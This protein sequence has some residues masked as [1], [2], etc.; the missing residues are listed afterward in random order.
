M[1]K[2]REVSEKELKFEPYIS[3]NSKRIA[4]KNLT[5]EEAILEKPII[6]ARN[7]SQNSHSSMKYE[8]FLMHRA[9]KFK[10]KLNEKVKKLE[11][12]KI[13]DCT[14]SPKINHV[15]PSSMLIENQQQKVR[16][17]SMQNTSRG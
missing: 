16:P 2:A 4:M 15:S 6:S 8:D 1:E 10:D 5:N 7:A 14:F 12:D 13:Q 3:R 9:Q 17:K 11:N